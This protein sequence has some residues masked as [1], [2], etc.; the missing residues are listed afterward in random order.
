MRWYPRKQWLA[1][2][3]AA[4]SSDHWKQLC[5]K[6][7]ELAKHKCE[8]KGCSAPIECHHHT[9][10]ERL[11]AELIS[12]C[13]S[14]C[15]YHHS[16]VHNRTFKPMNSKMEKI[17]RDLERWASDAAAAA[18]AKYQSPPPNESLMDRVDRDL[19]RE[20]KRK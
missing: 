10:Y 13:R 7:D 19:E 16:V 2:H 15:N 18:V 1:M 14:L 6:R 17:D 12:D 4:I 9:S 11:G 5:K 20:F 3:A 8:F